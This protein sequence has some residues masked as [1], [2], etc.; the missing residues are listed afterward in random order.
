M[1]D[2]PTKTDPHEAVRKIG[3][4]AMP[5]RFYKQ[6]T[7]GKHEGGFAV[8]LDGRAAK[9]PAG[10]PLVLAHVALAEAVA[11]EWAG[12]GEHLDPASMQLT[13]IANSAIDAVADRMGAVRTDITR[14][15]ES[16]LLCYRADGPEDLVA[17]QEAAWAPLLAFARETFGARFALA[18]GIMHVVQPPETLAA[19]KKALE[20]YDA[21][22]LAAI[23]TVT[24][25]TGSVVIALAVARGHLTLEA[26]WSAAHVDEDWQMSKWGQDDL[27][28]E[29]RAYRWREM[30]A[31]GMVLAEPSVE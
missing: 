9:T 22:A 18:E 17:S 20:G 5:K 11:K 19:I 16:D 15:A 27:A 10:K 21:L 14:H 6:A 24:T 25:L 29:T 31:A 26:A 23:H 13:R 2:E 7:I 12:Q 8:L 30:E 28:L 1:T 4:A 3:R